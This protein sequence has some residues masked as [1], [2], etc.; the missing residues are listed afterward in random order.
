MPAGY[1]AC[2]KQFLELCGAGKI[3]DVQRSTS[4]GFA[5]GHVTIEGLREDQG[6]VMT[7]H[8]QN[9]NLLAHVDGRLVLSV[10]DLIC[11]LATDGAPTAL[12]L[13]LNLELAL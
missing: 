8:F 9:E 11:C 13:Q 7:I 10:P 1:V 6:R 12:F 5:K 4:E 2:K 3:T